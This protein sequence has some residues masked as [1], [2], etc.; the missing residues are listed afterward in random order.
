[1]KS[2]WW[3]FAIRVSLGIV[4][5]IASVS[6]LPAQ[7]QFVN[8]V[9]G[10]GLLPHPLAWVYGMALPWVELAAGCSLILGVFTALAL[11]SSMLMTV[12]FLIANIY[13]LYQGVSDSC[14]C[15]GQLIP[16]SHTASLIIDVL[17]VFTAVLLLI[18]KRKAASLNI[19]DFFLSRLTLN[20]PNIP[21]GLIQKLG[22]VIL[23]AVIMLAIGLPLSLGTTTSSVYH[24]IDSSLEQ[25]K[26]VF[27]Y[28]YLEGCGECA[29]Q[30]PIIE[31]LEHVYQDSVSFIHVEYKTEADV[32]VDFE[33]TSVPAI[34]L[35]VGK[36]NDG[37][38]VFQRFS[39]FT[40]KY[41]LQRSLY[42]SPAAHIICNR[43]GPIAEFT[44]MPT[45]GYVPVKVQF[46]DSSLA[47]I[48]WAWE[49]GWYWDFD[50]DQVVDSR[51]RNPS[52][53]FEKPGTYT[54]SLALS[55]PCG[56]SNITKSDHLLFVSNEGSAL[57]GCQ[58][59]F[60]AEST[61]V[62]TVTPVQFLGDSD[63][64]IISWKWD[65]NSDGTIDS[66]ERN[67]VHTYTVA[68]IYTV[69]L[70]IK[71]ADCENRVIK[72]DYIRVMGCSCG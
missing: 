32:A 31:D 48:E 59:D 35:I 57:T 18:Y 54:V 49:F 56:S 30:K 15:F 3:L 41:S 19:G 60:L 40:D 22:Q 6:K 2:R 64:D 1:M 33:V 21:K 25:G 20:M 58:V 4:F 72:Q 16:L 23:L 55:G 38:T 53:V 43:Y 27:L 44:A 12:S 28:F 50:N 71:T 37:Y 8:E 11:V 51:L 66:T 7:S 46:T 47:Q 34:V 63:G 65:F 13:A 42:E 29:A 14:G 10:Y 9:A 17:M 70:T 61:A 36:N 62:D 45:S 67:P 68:G 69:S 39:H 26:P 5:I 24:E 52:H